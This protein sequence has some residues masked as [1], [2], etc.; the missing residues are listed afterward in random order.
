MGDLP[1][2]GE[3]D[4]LLGLGIG[5]FSTEDDL[6]LG[7]PGLPREGEDLSGNMVLRLGGAS[8]EYPGISEG[9]QG[10]DLTV[11]EVPRDGAANF[12]EVGLDFGTELAGR[13][14]LGTEL[15]G[16]NLVIELVTGPELGTELVEGLDLVIELV[17]GLDFVTDDLV[18]EL[19]PV[20]DFMTEEGRLAGVE[21][22]WR[23][24]GTDGLLDGVLDLDAGLLAGSTEDLVG[25]EDLPG[26]DD[27]GWVTGNF[28]G[29]VGREVGVED[30]S[31]FAA[32]GTVGR[33]FGVA[34]L[35][36]DTLQ[37]PEEDGLR[38]PENEEFIVADGAIWRDVTIVLE[39]ESAGLA[40]CENSNKIALAST[41]IH[42][43][44]TVLSFQG[45]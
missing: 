33:P 25:V 42:K 15:V 13:T 19:V 20:P 34:G 43:Q 16:L 17:P 5:P 11:G 14:D 1:L 45:K 29:N 27:L 32:V 21:L 38:I 12:D 22:A 39:E 35:D 23:L 10:L 24:D 4:C 26:V 30:L 40:S 36:E 3:Q 37:P 2:E 7:G 18:I 6:E 28:E 31:G 9:F 8:K 41:R 44:C